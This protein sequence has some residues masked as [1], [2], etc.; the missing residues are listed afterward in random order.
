M[1]DASKEGRNWLVHGWIYQGVRW[2]DPEQ[3]AAANAKQI[4]VAS[5]LISSWIL[6]MLYRTSICIFSKK[7][8]CIWLGRSP[9]TWSSIWGSSAGRESSARWQQ[10]GGVWGVLGGGEDVGWCFTYIGENLGFVLAFIVGPWTNRL[11]RV[12]GPG[13]REGKRPRKWAVVRKPIGP[14]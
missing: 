8:H 13:K 6:D 2:L 9:G 12:N 4:L 10:L 7:N 11:V 5:G 14:R 1:I 3:G